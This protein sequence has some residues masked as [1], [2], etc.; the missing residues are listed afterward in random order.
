MVALSKAVKEGY[1]GRTLQGNANTTINGDLN[2][3]KKKI[4]TALLIIR[5]ATFW[6]SLLLGVEEISNTI[7]FKDGSYRTERTGCGCLHQR[8]LSTAIQ[9]ACLLHYKVFVS[10]MM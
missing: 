4:R 5:A 9:E 2:A 10:M 6:N 3:S 7:N 8:E 1:K